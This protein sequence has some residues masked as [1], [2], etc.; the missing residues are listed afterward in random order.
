MAKQR[1]FHV[2]TLRPCRLHP[3]DLTCMDEDCD[4][5]C[6]QCVAEYEEAT[7]D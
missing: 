4:F 1:T 3:G 6:G 5:Q 7:W 2:H